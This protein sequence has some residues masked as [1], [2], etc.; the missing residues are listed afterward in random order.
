[1][2][3]DQIKIL[4]SPFF[5]GGAFVLFMIIELTAPGAVAAFMGLGALVTACMLEFG[6]V[7]TVGSA[8]LCW[9][10]STAI[11]A[12]VLWRPL[13][14]RVT[15]RDTTDAEEGIEP[16]I[17]D[18]GTVEDEP[19]TTAGGTIRLHG[20]RMQAVLSPEAEVTELVVGARVKVVR[21]DEGQRFVVMPSA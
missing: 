1:M 21:Q 9:L 3:F 20:A 18:F 16:F 12:A 4:L 11:V 2:S 6:L 13:K 15:T 7:E 17:N 8:L 14:R 19:L 5:W 10:A